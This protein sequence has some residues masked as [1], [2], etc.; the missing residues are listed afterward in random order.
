MH[1]NFQHPQGKAQ[2]GSDD[3]AGPDDGGE[4][5][6]EYQEL[7]GEG[8]FGRLGARKGA[9]GSSGAAADDDDDEEDGDTGVASEEEEEEE[10]GGAKVA[11]ALKGKEAVVVSEAVSD[12]D[13][14]KA[15]MKKWD[16]NDDEEEEEEPAAQG[17]CQCAPVLHACASPK[18]G[19]CSSGRGGL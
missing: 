3:E 11:P 7:G 13:Y 12:L 16:D 9:K 8:G 18:A 17:V 10:E 6:E 15:R 19:A 14:L 5:D 4:S 2:G 1:T